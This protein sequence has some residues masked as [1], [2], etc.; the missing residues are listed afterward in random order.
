ML[1]EN[2]KG[3]G[4]DRQSITGLEQPIGLSTTNNGVA[5]IKC[6]LPFN[7]AYQSIIFMIRFLPKFYVGEWG[8]GGGWIMDGD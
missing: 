4:G 5:Y 7:S 6:W 8:G 1:Q 3:G 2:G